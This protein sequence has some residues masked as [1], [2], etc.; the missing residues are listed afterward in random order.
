MDSGYTELR[1]FADFVY[2]WR[3]D[4]FRLHRQWEE[5]VVAMLV[6]A[7]LERQCSARV[8]REFRDMGR[9]G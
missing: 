4:A 8:L 3:D 9:G 6:E 5:A 7:T 1:D 2:E